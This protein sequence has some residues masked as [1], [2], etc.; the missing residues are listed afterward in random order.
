ML[1]LK[2]GEVSSFRPI[3]KR[4]VQIH[5]KDDNTAI[6]LT[7]SEPWVL[8]RGDKIAV[9]GE[10]DR[11]SGKFIAY[12][13]NNVSKSVVGKYKAPVADGIIIT[14]IG[15]ALLSKGEVGLILI[16]LIIFITG[17]VLT[18]RRFSKRVRCSR[19]RKQVLS[20]Q[21]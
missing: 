9:S 21:C 16:A 17:I 18:I 11:K 8:V 6:E 5:L 15:F 2:C 4:T 1:E 10:F 12:A 14:I 19:A 7:T 20:A 13:Y 3:S